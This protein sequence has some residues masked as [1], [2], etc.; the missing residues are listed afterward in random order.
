MKIEHPAYELLS[1]EELKDI[2]SEGY[3]LRHKKSGAT[4]ALIANDDD[5][6]VF[7]I[8][9]RTP[10]ADSTGVAH[11]TEHSTLCGSEKYPVKDP[12][13]ELV[14]GSLNTFLNAMTYPDKTVYPVASCNDKDFDNL[15]DVYMDA[16]FHP[17]IYIHPEIFKQEGWH[18]ELENPDDELKI[19]GVVYNEMKG[20][21][22]SPDSI[23][24]RVIMNSLFPDTPY[25]V[26]S[27]GDPA[28][29]PDLTYDQFLEFHSKYYHPSN[30]YIYLYGNMDFNEKL[31][32][33]DRE[34]LSQYDAIEVDSAIPLQKAFSKTQEVETAYPVAADDDGK[35]ETYLSYNV[36]VDTAL[37]PELY[38]A[39]DVLEYALLTSPGA[40]VKK[41]LTDAGIGKDIYGGYNSGTLQPVFSI[42]AKGANPED[43]ERFLTIIH[44]TLEQQIR[45]GIDKKALYAAINTNQ[46]HFREADFGQWP[47][48]L[49]Y[50]LQMLDSWLY[51][52][53]KPFM[54]LHGVGIL[55]GLKDKVNEGC[56]EDL[57]REYLLD[58]PHS[59]V[60]KAVPVAG[61]TAQSDEALKQKLAEYKASLTP[62]EID[63]LVADT[64]HLKEYQDTPSPKEDLE[65]IPMLKREDMRREIRPLDLKVKQCGRFTVLHHDVNTNGIHYLNLVFCVNNVA[66]EDLGYLTFMT[67]ILGLVDTEQYSYVDLSNVINLVT[68]GISASVQNYATADGGYQ[69]T[70]EVHSK[71]LYE[72]VES[73]I[74]LMEHVMLTS[75]YG[76]TQR[77]KELL[78]EEVS[79]M[80]GKL[81]SAGHI[82]GLTRA[83]SY[84]S[85]GGKVTD[86]ISGIGYYRFLKHLDDNFE[87]EVNLL[88]EKC[89][90]IKHA[91]FRPE[92]LLVSTTGDEEAFLQ[93]EKYLPR[94]ETRLFRDY[95]ELPQPHEIICHKL[96]EGFKSASQVQYVVRAGSFVKAGYHYNGAMKILNTILGYDF[97]W[98][99][100]RVKGGAYGCMSTFSRTGDMAFMSYRD[101]HLVQTNEIYDETAEWLR[102][103]S[104]DER[105]MTQY[106]IGT[107]SGMDTP[108]TPSMRGTRGLA[109]YMNGITEE[110]L[111]RERNQVIDAT[112]EDIRK[113]ADPVDAAMKQNYICV[114]GNEDKIEEN[115]DLFGT[116]ENLI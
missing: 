19:N 4:I 74:R 116:V 66:E 9:F 40:P 69:L 86:E 109:A 29:I 89:V 97:F 80:E 105:T 23:V 68:G 54:H 72:D 114:V 20:A 87:D 75:S 3:V 67:H 92:N 79:R 7:Y 88:K 115:K 37:N 113:L 73:A 31:D 94:I 45:D 107:I 8:G 42:T 14:K 52:E 49:M 90:N 44:D 71:F 46:F 111:Q 60:V 106:I 78:D 93:V 43:E 18:Y 102:N 57:I 108:L 48:G 98:I 41:A 47:K 64:R 58:N 35:D 16:V 10:P 28:H 13:V 85:V 100:L 112:E 25:G 22:S 26:E 36:V 12:F 56:F 77:L 15:M 81:L 76:D 110:T 17:N 65:K 30:S 82:V 53:T 5:N 34:Y 99:N 24:D 50:G 55:N 91:I 27:G 51:D 38:Q 59:S 84:F 83:G 33:L 1:Q 62:E 96:N 70:V 39:M 61:L 104:A 21:F 63:A 32:Y 95:Y 11:I 101:P 103:F 2:H 6:K